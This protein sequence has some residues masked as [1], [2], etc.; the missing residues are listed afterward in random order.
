MPSKSKTKGSTF[1]REA[2][3][4]LSELYED[5]FIRVKDSGAFTGGK[6]TTRK[7]YLS[8]GQIRSAKGDIVPPDNWNKFNVECKSYKEFPFHQLFTSGPVPL[9]EE[10]IEQTIDAADP[11]DINIIFMKFNRKGRY[12]AYELPTGSTFKTLRHLDYTDKKGRIWRITGFDDFFGLN[13]EEFKKKCI[14]SRD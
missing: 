9:L 11:G 5:S 8:S 1:E 3:R 13:S 2:S 4:F 12:V 10:W 7:D 6:N 14:G